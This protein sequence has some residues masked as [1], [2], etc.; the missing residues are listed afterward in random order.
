MITFSKQV[1]GFKTSIELLKNDVN[2]F[3]NV[4]FYRELHILSLKFWVKTRRTK[5]RG[6]L[7]SGMCSKELIYVLN[8]N[9][10]LVG[11]STVCLNSLLMI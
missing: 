7:T 11:S 5:S 2:M 10:L 6:I 8:R 1:L 3:M 4:T 9:A